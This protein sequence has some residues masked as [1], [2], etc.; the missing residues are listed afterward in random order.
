MVYH[1]EHG[2]TD[3]DAKGLAS[4]VTDPSLNERGRTQAK[5]SALKLKG[6]GITAIYHS[7]MKRAAETAQIISGHLGVKAVPRENLKPLDIGTLAGKPEG[8]VRKYLEFFAKR[9]GLKLPKGESFGDWYAKLKS[10]W[11]KHLDS[12]KPI[13]VVSH[14][15][16]WQLLKHL[17]KNGMDADSKSMEFGEPDSG[18]IAKA[19]KSGKSLSVRK[20]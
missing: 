17:A 10:E 4:G 2:E 8:T 9:P 6:K 7:P 16:D 18:Q 19:E 1:V 5:A 11:Q 13:A 12:G 14:S 15:R 3:N 20:I